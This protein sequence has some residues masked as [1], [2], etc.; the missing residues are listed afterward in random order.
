MCISY[1]TNIAYISDFA[2]GRIFSLN[3]VNYNMKSEAL[4]NKLKQPWAMTFDQL[5]NRLYIGDFEERTIFEYALDN[6]FMVSKVFGTKTVNKIYAIEIDSE[7]ELL[8]VSDTH[9]DTITVFNTTTTDIVKQVDVDSPSALRVKSEYL[10]V[11]SAQEGKNKNDSLQ[12]KMNL[13]L[14]LL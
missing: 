3:L 4:D 6:G 5:H 9:A 10:F 7:S 13:T 1:A 8:Y 12:S 2:N 14:S 11:C